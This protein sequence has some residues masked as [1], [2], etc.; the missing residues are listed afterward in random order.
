MS[1]DVERYSAAVHRRDVPRLIRLLVALAVLVVIVLLAVDNRDDTRVGY[2]WDD[3]TFPLWTVIVGS[4]V[5]GALIGWM[6]RFRS[7]HHHT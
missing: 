3:A 7:R 1:D 2:V 6:L 5:A 4:A